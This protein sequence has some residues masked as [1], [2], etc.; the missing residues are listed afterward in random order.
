MEQDQ[1]EEQLTLDDFNYECVDGKS[2]FIAYLST[3]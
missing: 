2:S 1:K 3:Y